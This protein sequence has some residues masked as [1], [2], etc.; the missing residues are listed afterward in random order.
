MGL[1]ATAR[2][3]IW[4]VSLGLLC[5]VAALRL[6]V[7]HPID[8]DILTLLPGQT[9]SP[10][11]AAATE[12]SRAA[13]VRQIQVLV[14]GTD[15]P[16]TRAA[17]TAA[18]DALEA[19][20]LKADAS[21]ETLERLLTVYQA[22]HFALLDA[23][24]S[25]RLAAGGADALATD[26][27]VSL[28][29]P[30]SMVSAFGSDPGGYL[31]RFLAGLPRPYPD[32]LPDGPFQSAVMDGE[33]HYLVEVDLSD[34]AFAEQGATLAASAVR[35]AEEAGHRACA[36]CRIRATGVALFTDVAR[37]EAEFETKWLTVV[38]TLLIMLLIA[39]VFR[40]L[41]PHVLAGTQLLASVLAASAA[42]IA[43][44]GSIQILTL[45]FGTTLLGI[46]V[47]YAFL[48][49]AEYW[50]GRSAPRAVMGR[51]RPGPPPS[52]GACRFFPRGPS[53]PPSSRG[54]L[55]RMPWPTC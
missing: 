43:C 36:D 7:H 26:V 41:A 14:S 22:H 17:A 53:P 4:L 42:V 1:P 30:A 8:T 16:E 54:W 29:S 6:D 27:A 3:A 20:G 13:F 25:Q 11:L 49:F 35:A 40:S 5:G 32:F 24:Q 10:A 48:Y 23:A 52:I 9:Q 31:G 19:A 21:G 38:S 12:R 51:V 2:W 46:A 28:A 47:D 37:R 39:Y 55:S 33:R 50:F 44:F 15:S 45:V 34:A 18:Q